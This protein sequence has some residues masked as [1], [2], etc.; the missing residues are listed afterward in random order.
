MDC[1]CP[2]LPRS[3]PPTPR[4]PLFK[5]LPAVARTLFPTS[6]R[7]IGA[8]TCKTD[9]LPDNTSALTRADGIPLHT[10]SDPLPIFLVVPLLR[11]IL[12]LIT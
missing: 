4:A 11:V 7:W 2:C 8:A 3:L 6:V 5:D 12:L 9:E 10:L 1:F